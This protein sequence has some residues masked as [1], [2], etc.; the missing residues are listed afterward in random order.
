ME[1][2]S[3]QAASEG[4]VDRAGALASSLCAAHCAA[5][6]L[7][8]AAFGAV[9]LGFLVSHD[10]EWVLTGIA[11]AFALVALLLGW[12]RHG[13]VQVAGFLVAGVIGLLVSRGLEAGGDHHHHGAEHHDA[14]H[15][16]G[17]AHASKSASEAKH[18]DETTGAAEHHEK[19][20]AQGDEHG[21]EHGDAHGDGEMTHLIGAGVGVLGGLLLLIGHVLNLRAYRTRPG[22]Y[23]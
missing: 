4:R 9:G 3:E 13:S 10:V 15:A 22:S 1:Q 17:E 5:S 20:E 6:A 12:R 16:E 8:P 23:T 18:A 11:V 14:H 7:V 21:D 2:A 19:G